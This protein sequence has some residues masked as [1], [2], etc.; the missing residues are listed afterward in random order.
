M[1]II[2]GFDMPNTC[3]ECPCQ[4]DGSCYAIPDCMR[5]D[6]YDYIT[7]FN[8]R[9]PYC[10]LVEVKPGLRWIRKPETMTIEE[11]KKKWKIH[12]GD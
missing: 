1:I 12:E 3:G 5:D 8:R 4:N 2:P 7:G 11:I 6:P 9:Q 10:P